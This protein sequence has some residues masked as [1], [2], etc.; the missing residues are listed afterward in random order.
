MLARLLRL[1]G[2]GDVLLRLVWRKAHL[3]DDRIGAGFDP[4]ARVT[5]LEARK[6]VFARDH[7]GHGVG[8]ESASAIARRDPDL[9]FVGRDDEDDAVTRLAAADLPIAAEPIS[10]I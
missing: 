6:N 2:C 4:A 3:F 5:G 1:L 9:P 10:I 8:Q 7:P